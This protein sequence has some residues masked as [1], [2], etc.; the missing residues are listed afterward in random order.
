MEKSPISQVEKL[1]GW[2]SLADSDRAT[3][4]SLVKKSSPTLKG[5]LLACLAL[6]FLFLLCYSCTT[7]SVSDSKSEQEESASKGGAKRKKALESDQK[8]KV[9]KAGV[10]T[11]TNKTPS[12][13]SNK[14]LEDETDNSVLESQLE[15]QSRALWALKDDLKKHVT[16]SVL[17]EMLEANE[18]DSRGSELDLRERW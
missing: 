13:S 4:L 11:S 12:S 7:C 3:L 1:P 10:N 16:T 14:N 9:A 17:R 2:D 18:Q 8:S 5:H 15:L 6:W